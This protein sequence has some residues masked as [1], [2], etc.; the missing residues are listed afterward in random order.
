[1]TVWQMATCYLAMLWATKAV[2]TL[3]VNTHGAGK[4]GVLLERTPR[5]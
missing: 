1:M 3:T 4:G 2:I 5:G